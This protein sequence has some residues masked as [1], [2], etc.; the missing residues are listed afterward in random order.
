MRRREFIALLGGTAA[1]WPL[2]ARAQ[3]RDRV[4]RI[5]VLL[6]TPEDDPLWQ[7]QVAAF[8]Q[9]LEKLGWTVG[10]NVRI[11]I[12]TAGGSPERARA[13][14][15]ELLA[16][17][18]DVILVQGTNGA[19][20]LQTATGTIPIVFVSVS[21]P[22]AQGFVASLR[23]PGGNMTGFTNLE[24]S[25]GSKWLDLLK[26]IAPD[27]S[28]VAIM[29]HR[30]NVSAEVFVHPLEAAAPNF[31]VVPVVAPVSSLAEIET[32]LMMLGHEPGGGVIIPSD[33]FVLSLRKR[34]A[35]LAMLY[36]LPMINANRRFA[37][38]GGLMSYG[39][40]PVDP[41]RQAAT[42]VDRILRGEK[43]ADLPVQNPTKFELV[44]NIKTAKALRLTVPPTL[45]AIADEVV[46]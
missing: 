42:Y 30:E 2:A 41:L 22:V 19:R 46:E 36:R 23:R 39:L 20:A 28:R 8:Q 7:S 21:E 1:A 27:V 3:Q 5:A 11:D 32:A 44:I 45:L 4:W 16:L 25:L 14:A 6:T 33:P 9:M 10:R 35:E 37:E 12:R 40:S 43:P 18:P 24:S 31:G 17:A 26:E 15:A 38:D 13:G 29:Y 34:V